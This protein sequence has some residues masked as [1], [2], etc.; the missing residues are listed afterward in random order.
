MAPEWAAG[1][2]RLMALLRCVW[3]TAED[4][5]R[6]KSQLL[7]A[8]GFETAKDI[9]TLPTSTRTASG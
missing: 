9:L 7:K 3:N 4:Q 1:L 6:P 8:A 5:N 2:F